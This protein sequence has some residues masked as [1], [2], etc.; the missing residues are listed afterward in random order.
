MYIR[1]KILAIKPILG[2]NAIS[3]ESSH[4]INSL[5]IKPE[6]IRITN[7]DDSLEELLWIHFDVNGKFIT[8]YLE[9]EPVLNKRYIVRVKNLKNIM[10]DELDTCY[11]QSINFISHINSE[12]RFLYPSMHSIVS[13]LY[14]EL[15]ET[16]IDKS[17][18]GATCFYY[19]VASD[20]LFHN[21]LLHQTP[22][23][24]PNVKIDLNY[25]GQIFIR[26][27]AQYKEEIETENGI[28]EVIWD[29]NWINT[30][31]VLEKEK[32]TVEQPSISIDLPLKII[33]QP[34]S[35]MAHD[36]FVYEFDT[37][38]LTSI[39]G[40]SITI[41]P[42][43]K[44]FPPKNIVAS[45]SISNNKLI[46][47]YQE[48][49]P[50]NCKIQIE[51]INVQ[52]GVYTLQ[53]HKQTLYSLLNPCYGDVEDV[54][55]LIDIK[56]DPEIVYY[57]LL[58]ASKLADYYADIKINGHIKNL[59]YY[60][61]VEYA[62]DF[63][64][65]MFVKNYVAGQ[66]LSHARSGLAYQAGFGGKLGEIEY[67]PKGSLIDL[68]GTIKHF[69]NEAEDWKLALQGYKDHP[70]DARAA[71][72]STKCLPHNHFRGGR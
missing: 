55:A 64:K 17:K 32:E 40:V 51:L 59:P 62:K 52:A 28:N 24:E 63:E 49:I 18:K 41:S 44:S 43:N 70:A 37:E 21:L 5:S 35:N 4:E 57:Y 46:I 19:E 1:F 53:H 25:K 11:S 36:N 65:Y 10:D 39:E 3:I 26:C 31:C 2:K 6:N 13:E 54:V 61:K 23:Y 12:I 38:Y 9:E 7:P 69:S 67:A 71:I 30:T 27:R 47:S 20:P 34:K 16:L 56:V 22:I 8:I 15:E 48:K 14:L 60:N 58:E 29:G 45:T 72:R 68:A 66:V 42:L 50:E 33:S